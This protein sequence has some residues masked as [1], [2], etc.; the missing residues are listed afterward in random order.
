M[1]ESHL[2]KVGTPASSTFSLKEAK[3]QFRSKSYSSC[4]IATQT[5]AFL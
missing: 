2:V 1:A 5:T 3:P 4:T